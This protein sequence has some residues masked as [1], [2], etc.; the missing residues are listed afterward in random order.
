M[1][2]AELRELVLPYEAVRTAERPDDVVLEFL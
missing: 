2:N 1:S